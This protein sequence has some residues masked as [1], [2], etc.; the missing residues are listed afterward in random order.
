MFP[1]YCSHV[2]MDDKHVYSTTVRIG[3]AWAG[4][5]LAFVWIM[6]TYGWTKA[7]LLMD[8][9]LSACSYGGSAITGPMAEANITLYWIRMS[10]TPSH[11]D[12]EDYLDQAQAKTR[13]WFLVPIL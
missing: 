12:I 8:T 1:E 3:G 13:G 11:A 4:I 6:K 5:G 7:A 9:Q 10:P 2:E